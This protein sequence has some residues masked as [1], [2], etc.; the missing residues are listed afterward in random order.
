[1]EQCPDLDKVIVP[2]SGGGLIG[3]VSTAIKAVKPDD[4]VCFFI[5]GGSVS[6]EQLKILEDMAL[7]G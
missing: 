3:G 4:K 2:V 7:H 1:M 5:S 6:L